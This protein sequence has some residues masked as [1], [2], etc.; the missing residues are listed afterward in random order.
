MN[1]AE[2]TAKLPQR[3]K[4]LSYGAWLIIPFALSNGQ[5]GG[6][7]APWALAAVAVAG[8][9]LR[10]LCALIGAAAGGWLFFPFQGALRHTACAV[11]I[12][13]ATLTF[14]DS[15]LYLKT[16]FR[17]VTTALM[18]LAVQSVTL[19][20]HSS[21]KWMLCAAAAAIAAACA[22]R[23]TVGT[24]YTRTVW[25]ILGFAAA[26]L[27]LEF[28][29]FSFGIVCGAWL[30]LLL[31]MDASP[32]QAAATGAGI[33]LVLDLVPARPSLLLAAG[34]GLAAYLAA[35]CERRW[36]KAGCFCA[37]AAA[38]ALLFD[39]DYVGAFIPALLAAG[40]AF[41]CIPK[42]FLPCTEKASR[43][44][45]G[46]ASSL[47]QKA[48]AFRELYEHLFRAPAPE[49]PE[50]P[51]VLFDRAAEQ[52]CRD[53]VLQAKCWQEEYNATYDAFNHACP[54]LL[55][56][57]TALPR[58]FPQTFSCRCVHFPELINAVNRSCMPIFCGGSIGCGSAA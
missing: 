48:A 21:P 54:Y 35:Q 57:G 9:N 27:P 42:R 24:P 55:Q 45:D 5:I 29:H 39:M 26:L 4:L 47:R 3:G 25:M 15:R 1:A 32:S 53:C 23:C 40:A 44:S 6:L 18:L 43:L 20:G 17:P 37:A 34:F 2:K 28:N 56:R 46:T 19:I 12:Y 49:K 38:T 52:V 58:D 36:C 11:L 13:A 7:Y 31:S 8:E 30:A 10:G 41:L 16:W 33:G 51:S 22:Y 50:N 14:A